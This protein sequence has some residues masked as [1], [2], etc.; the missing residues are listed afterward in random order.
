MIDTHGR[1]LALVTGASSGIGFELAKVLAANGYDLAIA[2]DRPL[3]DAEATIKETGADVALSLVVDLSQASG[4]DALVDRVEAL[5][6]PV[7]IL[8]ANAGHGLGEAFFDEALD[9]AMAVFQTNVLGSTRLIWHVGRKMRARGSGRILITSSTAS[10]MPGPFAAAYFASKAALQSF[11][12]SLRIECEQTGVSVTLLLPGATR[13]A[14]FQRARST[15]TKGAQGPMDS[16][17]EVAQAG[18][19]ALIKD[20]SEVI[21]GEH[22]RKAVQDA[23][24]KS[25]AEN[26]KQVAEVLRPIRS[27]N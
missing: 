27:D 5:G 21:F 20:E 8:C 14:F 23:R 18:Y 26:A 1:P 4:V 17:A 7:D 12:H 15:N 25:E 13:T 3:A 19:E 9:E 2:A 6:R 16:A 10:Q 11:G 22:N 24:T